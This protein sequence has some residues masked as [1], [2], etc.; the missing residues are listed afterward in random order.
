M[1][2]QTINIGTTPNDGTG[3]PI[4][5]SFD[6]TNQNFAEL[7]QSGIADGEIQ[8]GSLT[9]PS[10][11]TTNE[12]GANLTLK[13]N[14]AGIIVLEANT[15]RI[16]QTRTIVDLLLGAAGDVAGDMCWDENYIY[17]C[18]RDFGTG[19]PVWKKSAL[20]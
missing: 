2:Q 10:T 7:Y 11:I 15:V 1:A 6:K 8:L 12:T 19:T 13:P 17:V 5:V 20:S 4:R 16:S 3:D 14:A 9:A 18:V